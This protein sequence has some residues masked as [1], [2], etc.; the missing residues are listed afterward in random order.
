M[1]LRAG[2]CDWCGKALMK[3]R[4]GV[5]V[6]ITSPRTNNAICDACWAEQLVKE[7]GQ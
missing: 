6:H 1:R 7:A 3:R 2:V 4:N 5:L